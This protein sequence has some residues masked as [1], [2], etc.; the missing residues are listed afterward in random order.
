MDLAI[1]FISDRIK[2]EESIIFLAMDETGNPLGF[3]HLYPTFS[4]VYAQR[5]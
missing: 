4:S 3:T 1:K 5:I 2:N